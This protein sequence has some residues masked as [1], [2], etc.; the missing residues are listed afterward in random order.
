MA[1]DF[2]RRRRDGEG[3]CVR[4]DGSAGG[5]DICAADGERA[6]KADRADGSNGCVGRIPSDSGSD[7]RC[8]AVTISTGGGELVSRA[9]ADR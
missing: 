4:D 1:M 9:F 6:G 2:E 8:G 7:I 3:E 5:R